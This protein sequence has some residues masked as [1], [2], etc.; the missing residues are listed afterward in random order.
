MRTQQLYTKYLFSVM[1][2][3]LIFKGLIIVP[4][5]IGGLMGL[6]LGC[7]VLSL[8][9]I[10]DHIILG[11]CVPGR[12]P[13]EKDREP[14]TDQSHIQRFTS[15]TSTESASTDGISNKKNE[16]SVRSDLYMH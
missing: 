13:S 4:G 7:S 9:E 15:I 5:D 14:A 2:S 1:Q 10:I 16:E 11:C 8:V 12:K 3:D 6:L